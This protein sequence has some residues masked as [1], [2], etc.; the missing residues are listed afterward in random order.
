MCYG[1]T[2]INIWS[3]RGD[4]D[5]NLVQRRAKVTSSSAL[6]V[7]YGG[8]IGIETSVSFVLLSCFCWH[9]RHMSVIH[10]VYTYMCLQYL[11]SFHWR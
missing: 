11:E 10:V 6:S 3:T 1:G 4:H 8:R 9:W 2:Q 5:G 7:T